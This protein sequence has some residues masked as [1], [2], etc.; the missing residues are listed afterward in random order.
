MHITAGDLSDPRVL[1][2]LSEHLSNMHE[3]SPR[4]HVHALDA[5]HL[6]AADITF[7][8]IWDGE[9]LLGC[10]ALKELSPTHGEIKS[11]RTPRRLRRQGAGRAILNHLL[12]EARRRGY[13][14]LSLE[15]GTHGD[16]APAHALYRSAGFV[17]S[18]PFGAYRLYPESNDSTFMTLDLSAG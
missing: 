18:G 13:T 1:D 8:T 7:W 10:G 3:L 16:F 4:E 5:N 12:A 14:R 6:R 2:L 17:P 9:T 11:M 15:T